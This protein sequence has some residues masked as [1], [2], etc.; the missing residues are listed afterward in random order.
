MK[1]ADIIKDGR[2][3]SL[4][5]LGVWQSS[6]RIFVTILNARFN[7]GLIESSPADGD[8]QSEKQVKQAAEYFGASIQWASAP[9]MS[10]EDRVY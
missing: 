5:E 10:E 4:N 6:D 7:P 3:A 8:S 9:V 1:I 2:T